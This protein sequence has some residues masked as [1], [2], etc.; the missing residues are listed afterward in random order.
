MD[1]KEEES[2]SATIAP[3]AEQIAKIMGSLIEAREH[4]EAV[5]AAKAGVHRDLTFSFEANG[6]RY[7]LVVGGSLK[8]AAQE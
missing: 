5:S 7:I 1:S 3:D 2:G 6:V 4:L 8:K